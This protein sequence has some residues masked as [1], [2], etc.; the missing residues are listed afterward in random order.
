[1]NLLEKINEV[2]KLVPYLQKATQGHNYKY[3]SGSSLLFAIHSKMSELGLLL[4]P[5][6]ND[7]EMSI[8]SYK[9]AKGFDK[10]DFWYKGVVT[11][12]WQ[13]IET[14]DT[15]EIPFYLTGMQDDPSKAFGSALTYSER[16]FLMKF[17][18]IATDEDDPDKFSK[19]TDE[20]TGNDDIIALRERING[21]IAK[22]T[23]EKGYT[24]LEISDMIKQFFGKENV[25]TC[26][27]YKKLSDFLSR[28]IL[29]YRSAKAPEAKPVNV[30]IEVEP[31][32][33]SEPVLTMEE[34]LNEIAI[35]KFGS[36]DERLI[37]IEEIS[38]ADSEKLR[39]IMEQI[40]SR[41]LLE[42]KKEVANEQTGE[43]LP[44]TNNAEKISELHKRITKGISLLANKKIDKFD[45]P[46]RQKNSMKSHLVTDKLADATD[47][48][49]LE[50]YYAILLDKYNEWSKEGKQ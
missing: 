41:P 9:N 19:R 33:K 40:K 26:N 15:L 20:V 7:S 48:S 1:M 18:N 14:G 45:T 37:F 43:V 25:E 22:L 50:A 36:N 17:L 44:E 2:R 46:A 24:S 27:N 8:Y 28:I 21:G 30:N 5:K 29:I 31:E 10:T 12:I 34:V 38:G 39:I 47:I 35:R 49:K 23:V 42:Q 4:Y 11:Y 13:D 32:T 16:Y 3:V 6:L